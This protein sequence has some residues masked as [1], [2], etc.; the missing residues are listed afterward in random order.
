M[1]CLGSRRTYAT[2]AV[3]FPPFRLSKI[4][5]TEEPCLR[6]RLVTDIEN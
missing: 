2:M 1:S 5:N 3:A 4:P 6:L